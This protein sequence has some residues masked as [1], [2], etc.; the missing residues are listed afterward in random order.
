MGEQPPGHLTEE[1][2]QALPAQLDD[3]GAAVS[4]AGPLR[5]ARM[6]GSSIA[7]QDAAAWRSATCASLSAC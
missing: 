4:A 5:F 2:L 1:D 3:V 6:T 7:G